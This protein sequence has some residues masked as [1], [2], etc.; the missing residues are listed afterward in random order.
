VN[1]L[2][3]MLIKE[4]RIRGLDVEYRGEDDRLR[5]VGHLNMVDE[6]VMNAMRTAKK[7]LLDILKPLWEEG[8]GK[9]VR[10]PQS[11]EDRAQ[12]LHR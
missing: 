1:P 6:D 8:D 2:L 5:L 9:P 4:L 7:R 12:P 11:V 3:M 10:L